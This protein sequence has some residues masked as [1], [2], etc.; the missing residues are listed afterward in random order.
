MMSEQVR[1]SLFS[2]RRLCHLWHQGERPDLRHFLDGAGELSPSQLAEVLRVDQRERWRIGERVSAGSYL[3]DH[4]TVQTDGEAAF[5][6]IYSEFL[7]REEL[8]EAPELEE[9]S[10]AYPQYGARLQ[11]Q[12]EL[13]GALDSSTQD[14]RESD[15]D[16]PGTLFGSPDSARSERFSRPLRHAV[17]DHEI[18]GEIGRGG[19]GVV[20]RARQLRLNRIVALKMI[21][22]G[23]HSSDEA[24]ARFLNEAEVI[25]RIQHPNIVQIH[26][27]GG[28]GERPFLVME[29]VEGGSL[30]QLLDGSPRPIRTAAS[31]VKQVAAGIA[32]AHR[33]GIVHRDLKPAN[34]LLTAGGAPK[35]ADF[36][37]AKILETDSSLTATES[38]L[39]TA[40]YMA[41]EQAWGRTHPV[42]PAADIYSLGAIL[43]ELLTG[44]P[45]FRATTAL[46]TVELVKTHEPVPPGLLRPGLDKD[47]ETICLKCLTKEPHCRYAS[48][49]ALADDLTRYKGGAADPGP[50]CGLGG[51]VLALVPAQPDGRGAPGNGAGPG[52]AG[53]R[54]RDVARAAAGRATGGR[55]PAPRR[56]TQ[57]RRHGGG[58]GCESPKSL[59]LPRSARAA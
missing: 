4:P 34:I 25:A 53:E 47:V 41:P 57:R 20:Y 50:A 58:S 13:H 44:R 26:H 42:G 18:L 52:W 7:L 49:A 21:L 6:L 3:R 23:D 16:L 31:L 2:A 28:D 27:C 54:R 29:Y 14:G 10:R 32:A 33:K 40:S 48:A 37:L 51:P 11:L 12:L 56:A 9:Y 1:S 19:M 38:I 45:P 22:A 35:V 30:A 24:M 5:E 8:G 46:E 36:G 43:Y 15:L 59:P 39:G 55:G 17:P